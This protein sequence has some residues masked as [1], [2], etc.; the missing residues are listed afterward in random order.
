[1]RQGLLDH[2]PRDGRGWSRRSCCRR[3]AARTR[4]PRSSRRTPCRRKASLNRV[5][6]HA[7]AR[8]AWPSSGSRC[9]RRAGY[10]GRGDWARPAPRASSKSRRGGP[11]ELDHD[12]GVTSGQPLARAEVEGAR[13]PQRQFLDLQPPWPRN[14]SVFEG[15]GDLRLAPVTRDGL[16]VDEPGPVLSPHRRPQHVLG[17]ESWRMALEHLDALVPPRPPRGRTWAAPWPR[18][19]GAEACGSASCSRTTPALS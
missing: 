1:M 5:Q 17:L 12:L 11:A 14:V 7:R 10:G 8:D 16:A 19:R 6:L 9:P 15:R 2:V 13:R 4:W 3:G 18:G